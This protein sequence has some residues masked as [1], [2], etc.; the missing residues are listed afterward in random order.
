[1]SDASK[2]EWR[3]YLDD[4]IN[5]RKRRSLTPTVAV[6]RS[7]RVSFRVLAGLPDQVRHDEF[8]FIAAAV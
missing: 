3:F 4:M 1:M 2:R 6:E 7:S 8:A 5:L